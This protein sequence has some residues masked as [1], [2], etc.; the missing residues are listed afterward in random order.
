MS[1]TEKNIKRNKVPESGKEI[2]CAKTQERMDDFS[3]LISDGVWETDCFLK[4]TYVSN[5]MLEMLGFHLEEM[6][7]QCLTDFGSFVFWND[8][9]ITKWHSPHNNK[10][11]KFINKKGKERTFLINSL[12]VYNQKTNVFEG[13]RGSIRTLSAKPS[14]DMQKAET[15][16]KETEKR[17]NYR[18]DIINALHFSEGLFL[19][20]RDWL[21]AIKPVIERIGVTLNISR[22][23]VYKNSSDNIDEKQHAYECC[24][25]LAPNIQPHCHGKKIFTY[26]E[27]GFELWEKHF[28]NGEIL[29]GNVSDFPLL[30]KET[31]KQR[32]IKSLIVVPVFARKHWWGVISFDVSENRKW[33]NIEKNSILSVADIFGVSIARANSE[34]ELAVARD[35]AEQ[36]NKSKSTFL[37]AMSHELRTPLNAVIGFSELMMNEIFGPLGAHQYKE[38]VEDI[39]NS[40]TYLL[41]M[42]NDVLDLSKV[43]AG[44]ME[45]QEETFHLEEVIESSVSIFK[46]AIKAH[47]LKIDIKLQKNLPMLYGDRRKVKQILLNLLSNAI[48]F[49]KKGGITICCNTTKNGML[50]LLVSDTGIGIAADERNKVFEPF[51][52]V[53]NVMTRE[54]RGTGLGI[55]LTKKFVQLH[56]GLFKLDSE[57][58]KGTTIT[59]SFPEN[60]VVSSK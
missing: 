30:G 5:K 33:N 11:F 2:S 32:N 47:D 57:Q 18:I 52:Q 38:Y 7:G 10:Q 3:H 17:L 53:E 8:S 4:L 13:V 34:K 25:W 49:T 45:L 24:S 41:S 56:G 1:N 36:A 55:P 51:R 42:I 59:I 22:I 19:K 44:R 31:L 9:D 27:L 20:K 48:K 58:G 54:H 35:E 60:R 14:K 29:A 15:E 23:H 50:Q 40:G 21:Q 46:K 37:A 6:I 28:I 12:P 26:E 16:F 43:E 39:R